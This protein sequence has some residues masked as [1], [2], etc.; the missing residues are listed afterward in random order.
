MGQPEPDAPNLDIERAKDLLKLMIQ[1]FIGNDPDFPERL[2]VKMISS[3]VEKTGLTEAEARQV[4][5]ALIIRKIDEAQKADPTYDPVNK[6]GKELSTIQH[7][8]ALHKVVLPADKGGTK[9]SMGIEKNEDGDDEYVLRME[10][11]VASPGKR[12][13]GV[14]E[15]KLQGIRNLIRGEFKGKIKEEADKA[16][17]VDSLEGYLTFVKEL[18]ENADLYNELVRQKRYE[19]NANKFLHR[20]EELVK[21][22]ETTQ[23]EAKIEVVE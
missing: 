21:G 8:A 18:S 12:K 1:T 4:L 11:N 16:L 10:Y 7:I 6:R 20:I 15:E 5:N 2:E 22:I 19:S 9:I 23:F 13:F 17:R 3:L 14:L